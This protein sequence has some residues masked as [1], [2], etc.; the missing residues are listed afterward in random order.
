MAEF[1]LFYLCLGK[2]FIDFSEALI[3]QLRHYI[4]SLSEGEGLGEEENVIL[5]LCYHPLIR[6][7]TTFSLMKK[8]LVEDRG[9]I[10]LIFKST[11]H[12]K[13]YVYNR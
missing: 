7:S 9:L 1:G 8:E 2:R 12:A 4:Y 5:G 6:P 13:Q 11:Q 3:F 10:G